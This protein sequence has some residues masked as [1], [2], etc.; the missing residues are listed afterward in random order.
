MGSEPSLHQSQEFRL[1]LYTARTHRKMYIF[2][3]MYLNSFLKKVARSQCNKIDGWFRHYSRLFSTLNFWRWIISLTFCTVCCVCKMLICKAPTIYSHNINVTKSFPLT[4]RWEKRK[5]LKLYPQC[6]S[7]CM[8]HFPPLLFICFPQT[9]LMVIMVMVIHIIWYDIIFKWLWMMNVLHIKSNNLHS[10]C[11]LSVG[12]ENS[13]SDPGTLQPPLSGWQRARQ[14]GCNR[15][16]VYFE[17][18]S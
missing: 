1:T 11:Q 2:W 18:S 3:K 12:W 17:R 10:H 6:L 8:F 7:Y 13:S 4:Y 5:N 14:K 9:L 16:S 15:V